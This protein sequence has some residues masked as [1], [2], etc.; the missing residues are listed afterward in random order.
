MITQTSNELLPINIYSG[1]LET[2]IEFMAYQCQDAD[3]TNPGYVLQHNSLKQYMLR[4][5]FDR[6]KE[7]M[8]VDIS[9][10]SIECSL[11]H[12][13]VDCSIEFQGYKVTETGEACVATLNSTI[14]K[15]YPYIEAQTRAYDRAV[16][17]FLQLNI[18]GKRIYSDTELA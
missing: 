3:N 14:A 4:Y 8:P 13:V 9:Y 10:K 18:N 11:S 15:N 12:S 5:Q 7:N 2:N 17:S 16:I 1:L 6:A